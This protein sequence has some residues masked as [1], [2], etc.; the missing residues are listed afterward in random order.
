MTRL[1]NDIRDQITRDLINHRFQGEYSA[2]CRATAE[3][4]ERCYAEKFAKIADK[5]ER[6]PGGWLPKSEGILCAFGGRL[7]SLYFNG[8]SFSAA[9]SAGLSAGAPVQKLF[10]YESVSNVCLSLEATHPLSEEF[11]RLDGVASDLRQRVVTARG[12]AAAALQSVSTVK[13]LVEVW[14]EVEPFT[15]RHVAQ[16]PQLP[17]VNVDTLNAA[18]ELPVD[19][20]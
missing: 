1:T 7:Q 17:S 13:R 20:A 3:L 15:I 12:S 18:L 14:P 10:P 16:R 19:A 2:L 4:A 11:D 9:W 6:L 8:R 5:M